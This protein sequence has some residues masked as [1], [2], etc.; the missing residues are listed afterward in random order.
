MTAVLG[1]L[2]DQLKLSCVGSTQLERV[3]QIFLSFISIVLPNTF[4]SLT[5]FFIIT[6]TSTLQKSILKQKKETNGCLSEIS[7]CFKNYQNFN[8]CF[9]LLFCFIF[10]CSTLMATTNL[11]IALSIILN[12]LRA[13]ELPMVS[14]QLLTFLG[15]IVSTLAISLELDDLHK[16]L[17]ALSEVLDLEE[18][19]I[20]KGK[21]RT[22]VRI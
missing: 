20:E 2:N 5:V 1:V 8:D 7:N 10:S 3:M 6:M 14:A 15:Q 11:Y 21:E 17:V 19:N 4:F 12:F 9:G 13:E 22:V 16:N 18:E